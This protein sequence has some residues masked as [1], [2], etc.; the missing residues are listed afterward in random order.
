MMPLPNHDSRCRTDLTLGEMGWIVAFSRSPQYPFHPCL[1]KSVQRF[2]KSQE[3][4]ELSSLNLDESDV[5]TAV[6]PPDASELSDEDEG[7][8][9]RILLPSGHHSNTCERDYWSDAETLALYIK[10]GE[11]CHATK[12]LSKVEILL[13]VDNGTVSQHVQD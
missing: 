5:E 7:D 11:K 8:E 9:K 6:L 3:A 12:L 13:F 2:L 10:P 1:V 4:L